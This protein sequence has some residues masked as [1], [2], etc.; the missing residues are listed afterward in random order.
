MVKRP[1]ALAADLQ[2]DLASINHHLAVAIIGRA[3]GNHGGNAGIAQI[4]AFKIEFAPN[5]RNKEQG[6]LTYFNC[7]CRRTICLLQ[8]ADNPG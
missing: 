3:T 8:L 1:V 5:V 6:T 7:L 4:S 2:I